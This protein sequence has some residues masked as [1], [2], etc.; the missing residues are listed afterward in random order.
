MIL[1]AHAE[2]VMMKKICDNILDAIGH[3]PWCVST[4]SPRE[5]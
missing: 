1:A 3:T 4:G 5:P 2:E